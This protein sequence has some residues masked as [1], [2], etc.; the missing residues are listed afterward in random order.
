M[1]R[2]LNEYFALQLRFYQSLRFP[3]SGKELIPDRKQK[4]PLAS[5]FVNRYQK[6]LA[7]LRKELAFREE[8]TAQIKAALIRFLRQQID[9]LSIGRAPDID[10]AKGNK[11]VS[12]ERLF[13]SLGQ[14][15][16]CA[17]M[18][19]V[20]RSD[21]VVSYPLSQV[22]DT[23]QTVLLYFLN[24]VLD[25]LQTTTMRNQGDIVD[26]F[27]DYAYTAIKPNKKLMEWAANP[28]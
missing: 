13:H 12:M 18:C 10:L 16:W 3:P 14:L 7:V 6:Q 22:D 2:I 1:K 17:A 15:Y 25:N 28:Y 8:G 26:F 21:L 24:T 11:E 27:E 19:A 5:I 9:N 20:H 23:G 4:E